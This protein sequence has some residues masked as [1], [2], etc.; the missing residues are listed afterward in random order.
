LVYNRIFALSV[1]GLCCPRTL[2]PS[3]S[4]SLCD[5]RTFFLALA[6]L[7]PFGQAAA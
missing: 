1:L 7:V 4:C 3:T 6:Q 2:H 5:S